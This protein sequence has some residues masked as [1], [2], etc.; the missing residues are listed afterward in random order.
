MLERA[1]LNVRSPFLVGDTLGSGDEIAQYKEPDPP[2]GTHRYVLLLFRQKDDER[3]TVCA[4]MLTSRFCVSVCLKGWNEKHQSCMKMLRPEASAVER[5]LFLP[6]RCG[7]AWY[8]Q[9]N[10]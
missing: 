9:A 2:E 3:I 8:A 10:G 6:A 7:R 5:M 4:A 1:V